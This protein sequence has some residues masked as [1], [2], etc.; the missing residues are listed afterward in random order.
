MNIILAILFILSSLVVLKYSKLTLP[1][2]FPVFL[3]KLLQ[4][5]KSKTKT[6]EVYKILEKLSLSIITALII[7]FLI[8][9]VPGKRNEKKALA[10]NEQQLTNVYLNMGNAIAPI[11]MV[12][13]INK[14]NKKIKLQD[15][16]DMTTYSEK[17]RSK[18]YYKSKTYL[19]GRE[20]K[21]N[22]IG[23]FLYPDDLVTTSAQIKKYID[24][25]NALPSSS[26]LPVKLIETLSSIR[27]SRFLRICGDF[28]EPI[29]KSNEINVHEFDL[30]FYEFLKLYRELNDFKFR[31]HSYVYTQLNEDEISEL[32]TTK[33][34][35]F[36]EVKN[37]INKSNYRFIFQGIEYRVV[38]GKLIE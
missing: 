18:Y 10:I 30:A 27:S 35:V 21:V 36:K 33:K 38:D 12:L 37:T 2:F 6:Y 15:L 26:N 23:I 29:T 20:P 34:K 28:E 8:D 13:D 24:S 22:T 5:P 31:K 1:P 3:N 17:L 32:V 7:F 14:K 4:N 16:K 11:K 19:E 25:I 9:F